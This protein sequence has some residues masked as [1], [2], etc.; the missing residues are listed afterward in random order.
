MAFF[1]V[2]PLRTE[3]V[4]WASCQPYLPCA[5][6]SMLAVLVYLR[7]FRYGPAPHWGWLGGSFVLVTAALLSKAVAVSVPLVL[8]ILDVYPL[9][10]LGG[11]LAAGSGRRRGR[12]GWRRF[13]SP[14]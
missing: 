9:G 14:R 4:A 13:R 8:L 11:A 5:L 10:R 3:V 12:S 6:F 2:N 1:A 7:A